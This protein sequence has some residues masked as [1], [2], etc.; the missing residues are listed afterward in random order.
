MK[1]VQDAGKV[2]QTMG[3]YGQ[4]FTGTTGVLLN[5]T[6]TSFKVLSDTMIRAIVPAGATTGSVTV[7]TPSGTLKSNVS[8]RVI[9]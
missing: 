8:F 5:G 7:E 9:P 4:G 1:L 6:P 2:E 3:I